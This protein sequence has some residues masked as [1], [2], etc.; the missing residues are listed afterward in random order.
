MQKFQHVTARKHPVPVLAP[1]ALEPA[2]RDAAG[3]Q[4]G[5]LPLQRLDVHIEQPRRGGGDQGHF[6][7]EGRLDRGGLDRVLAMRRC[8]MRG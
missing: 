2:D 1:Q 3:F 5:N 8:D 6:A 4:G 7:G